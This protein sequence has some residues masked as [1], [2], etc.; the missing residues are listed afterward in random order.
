MSDLKDKKIIVTGATGGIGNSIVEKLYDADINTIEKILQIS[1]N[2][3][4]KDD[5]LKV[6]GFKEK[7]STNLIKCASKLIFAIGNSSSGTSE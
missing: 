7:S 4:G 3:K 2:P 1:I 6:E 5:L